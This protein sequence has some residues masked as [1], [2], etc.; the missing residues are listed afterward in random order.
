MAVPY[1][2]RRRLDDHTHGLEQTP[3]TTASVDGN[4]TADSP[5]EI[6]QTEHN[7]NPDL[8]NDTDWDAWQKRK[9]QQKETK[10]LQQ[11][12]L[13]FAERMRERDICRTHK[14]EKPEKY[15]HVN[16]RRGELHWF[17]EWFTKYESLR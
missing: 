6:A 13:T 10:E 16:P 4:S 11:P 2:K 7:P 14:G 8:A 3:S 5:M 17:Q 12:D 15:V 9:A 1:K